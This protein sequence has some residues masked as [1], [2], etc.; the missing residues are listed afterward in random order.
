MM[1]NLRNVDLNLLK[2]FDAIMEERNISRAA[3]RLSVSQPAISMALGRLR[4]LYEDELFLRTAK[5]VAPTPKAY[6]L[7]GTVRE[8]ISLIGATL[9]SD[10]IFRP[11][12]SHRVFRVALTD[13]GEFYFLPHIMRE[14]GKH[15]PD[16]DVVCLPDPGAS[17][18]FDMK[19]GVVDLVWDWKC[20]EDS[21]YVA[22]EIFR[23][24][25]YCITRKNHPLIDGELTLDRF[26]ELEHAVLRPTQT[27]IPKIEQHLDRMGL[28]RKIVAEVSHVL[29]IPAIVASTNL[30]AIMPERLA[31]LFAQQL[32]LDIFPNPVHDDY[33]SVYQMW[34]RHFR[35]DA[36]HMWFREMLKTLAER[37]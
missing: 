26:L 28:E 20:I 3:E 16:T 17:L 19:S 10:D 11:E 15:A 29:V 23:D 2:V 1:R 6:E 27:H 33:I 37:Y 9:D 30:V 18:T 21:N 14:L 8:A 25:S 13:Y 4:T 36:G 24:K 35:K 22:E 31:R 7:E 32:S 34:H 12:N 5:G